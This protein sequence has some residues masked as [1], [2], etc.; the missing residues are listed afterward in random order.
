MVQHSMHIVFMYYW[1]GL[2]GLGHDDIVSETI[3][4][5]DLSEFKI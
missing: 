5:H 2:Y 3:L 4:L 1:K